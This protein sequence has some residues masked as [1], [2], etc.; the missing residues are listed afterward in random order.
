[1]LMMPVFNH[2]LMKTYRWD[3]LS[4]YFFLIL[5]HTAQLLPTKIPVIISPYIAGAMMLVV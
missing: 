4:P 3:L 2:C 1:M 5:I